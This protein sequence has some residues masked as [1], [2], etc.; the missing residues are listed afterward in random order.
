MAKQGQHNNDSRDQDKSKGPNKPSK[1]VAIT[2]GTP[3][4]QETYKQQAAQHKPND[5]QPQAA[6]HEWNED[7]RDKPSN[8]NS[9]RARD[10]DIGS[11]RSGS[12]SN[13]DKGTKN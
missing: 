4:K 10:S 8:E 6:Q 11:G 12:D 2:T 3:K 1:S 13:A 9:P 7:T 5:G